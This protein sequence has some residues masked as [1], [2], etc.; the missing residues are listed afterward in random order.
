MIPSFSH[1]KPRSGWDSIRGPTLAWMR[2]CRRSQ[3]LPV[4]IGC[5]CNGYTEARLVRK[6]HATG[7]TVI[8]LLVV[9]GIVGLVGALLVASIVSAR[10][11]ARAAAC[12]NNLRQIVAAA[13]MYQDQYGRLPLTV[14]TGGLVG[15]TG[16]VSFFDRMR[17]QMGYGTQ[18]PLL[19]R[20]T[21]NRIG[22]L[23]C[24]TDVLGSANPAGLS[25]PL[26]IGTSSIKVGE[27]V[28]SSFAIRGFDVDSGFSFRDVT[29]GTSQ[30]AIFCE[31]IGLST[32]AYP[33]SVLHEPKSREWSADFFETVPDPVP[34]I[35]AWVSNCENGPR[36]GPMVSSS[37]GF[38]WDESGA[39][40]YTHLR[41]VNTYHC[42]FSLTG[43]TPPYI[44]LSGSI[45]PATSGHSGGVHVAFADG[46][47]EFVSNSIDQKVW[48]KMGAID[49]MVPDR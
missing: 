29:A 26:N 2:R 12:R 5:R 11:T 23:V 6:R 45:S 35:K 25:Y 39:I 4:C 48:Y 32:V 43:N 28:F 47:V 21:A 37:A 17:P 13:H 27:I 41:K 20:N 18:P 46:H 16:H 10:E 9:I 24:P 34:G 14:D 15:R 22:L 38:R 8:E 36:N 1:D 3:D 33:N 40:G 30:V 42:G 31:W 19:D 49:G 44:P 7:F